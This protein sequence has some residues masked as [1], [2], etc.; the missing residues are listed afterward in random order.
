MPTEAMIFC[1]LVV[2][3]FTT[4]GV[5]LAYVQRATVGAKK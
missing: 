5:T 1:T 4:L 3:A 2:L